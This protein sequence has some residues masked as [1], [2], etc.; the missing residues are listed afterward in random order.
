VI[1]AGSRVAPATSVCALPAANGVIELRP[2]RTFN[3]AERGEAV[4]ISP[5][6]TTHAPY[7]PQATLDPDILLIT[8]PAPAAEVLTN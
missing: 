3:F 1:V 6:P 2:A 8:D 7:W 4:R 5:L